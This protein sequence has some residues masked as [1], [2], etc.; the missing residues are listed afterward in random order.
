VQR[1]VSIGVV[2]Y[3]FE[4]LFVSVY[5]NYT[6]ITYQWHLCVSYAGFDLIDSFKPLHVWFVS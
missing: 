2:T 6:Q 4:H 1:G 5:S 3:N